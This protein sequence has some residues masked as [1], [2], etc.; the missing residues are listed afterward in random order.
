MNIFEYTAIM[1]N[2]ALT[3]ET[4]LSMHPAQVRSR[5]QMDGRYCKNLSDIARKL[6]ISSQQVSNV[7]NH[8]SRVWDAIAQELEAESN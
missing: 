6:G 1:P 4:L 2:D 8:S 7:V 3:K 5:L